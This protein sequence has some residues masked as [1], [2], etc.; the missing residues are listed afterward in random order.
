MVC[1]QRLA[2]NGAA[3][4]PPPSPSSTVDRG[5][6]PR[7]I[8]PAAARP[9][10]RRRPR[11][12]HRRRRQDR[13]DLRE[14][15]GGSEEPPQNRPKSIPR[16]VE[17]RSRAREN[18]R[19][20]LRA[21]RA[22]VVLRTPV[23]QKFHRACAA[24]RE[25]AKEVPAVSIEVPAESA[26]GATPSPPPSR[27]QP[28]V[29]R[30]AD[31]GGDG[32]AAAAGGG[33]ADG[34]SDGE[35]S[36]ATPPVPRPRTERAHGDAQDAEDA[37]EPTPPAASARDRS[38]SPDSSSAASRRRRRGGARCGELR[39]GAGLPRARARSG[40]AERDLRRERRRVCARHAGPR[41]LSV[42]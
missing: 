29:R 4:P 38:L 35:R 37:V 32:E 8:A 9:A 11:R 10:G 19:R 41:S 23:V 39:G 5:N 6:L 27:R 20:A 3:R 30:R 12:R 18:R 13:G 31:G 24:R 21:R 1:V 2:R 36:S 7:E 33:E 16:D 22:S 28:Q 26:G 42:R 15:F 40:R 34:G 14:Q 25:S 17:M